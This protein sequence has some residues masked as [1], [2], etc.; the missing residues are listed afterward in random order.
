MGV[1]LYFMISGNMPF[2]GDTVSQ[3][4][5]VILKGEYYQPTNF[6]PALQD[7]ISGILTGNASERYTMADI[8]SSAWMNSGT[9][10]SSNGSPSV[11]GDSGI[12]T[13]ESTLSASFNNGDGM[14]VEVL[15]F[16]EQIGVPTNDTDKLLGEPRNPIAGTYRILLHRKHTTSVAKQGGEQRTEHETVQTNPVSNQQVVQSGTGCCG[17]C[18]GGTLFPKGKKTSGTERGSKKEC[19]TGHQKSKLCIIL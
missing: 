14:D 15:N 12:G 8:G 4:K 11:S 19:G 10:N 9:S 6:T 16:L 13:C 5:E 17:G 1:L 7:L 18:A 3:L 2:R